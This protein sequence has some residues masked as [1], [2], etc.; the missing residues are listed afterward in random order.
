MKRLMMVLT[1][2]IIS[3]T[4]YAAQ[5]DSLAGERH[6]AK[7]GVYTPAEAKR[8]AAM[9]EAGGEIAKVEAAACCS[10]SLHG[11]LRNGR[12]E[13]FDEARYRAKYGRNVPR[14]EARKTAEAKVAA[15]HAH[16]CEEHGKCVG[17][18]SKP[19]VQQTWKEARERAKYGRTP[20]VIT[21]KPNIVAATKAPACEH[22]CCSE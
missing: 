18:A 6:K 21:E 14:L 16:Q 20:D 17:A 11:D 1:G 9:I 13:T 19:A 2:T 10:R 12:P 7:Y 8:R 22:A 5:S 4:A 15:A 3:F